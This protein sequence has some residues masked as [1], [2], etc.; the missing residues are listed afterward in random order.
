V[1]VVSLR[2]GEWRNRGFL[3]R[4]LVVR[5]WR[6]RYAGSL[7]SFLWAFAQPAAQLV[8][9]TFVFATVLRVPAAGKGAE[10]FAVFLFCGLLPWIGVNEGM[11]RSTVAL[12]E[13]AYLVRKH[14][15]PAELL[16][17]STV[18]SS[19][20]QQLAGAVIFGGYLVAT[21]GLD[22]T[23]L[24]L[25]PVLVAAQALFSVGLGLLLAVGQ[26]VLRDVAQVVG[27]ALMVW[28]YATPIIYPAES[29]PERWAWLVSVN[30]LATIVGGYRWM[31][32]GASAGD[33]VAPVAFL[34]ATGAL[35]AG[36]WWLFHRL[37]PTLAD[38]L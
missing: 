5:D 33:A 23:R 25:L 16:V 4:E 22:A 28:F 18:L 9:F 1:A 6:S 31:L 35:L 2:G 32:L 11:Q 30:P 8:L 13:G 29:V 7:L 3:L 36:G 21:R 14:R 27:I 37:R 15:F 19:L 38:E 17:V 24:W 12:T 20:L 34:V 26:V 10:D